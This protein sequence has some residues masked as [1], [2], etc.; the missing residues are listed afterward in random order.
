MSSFHPFASFLMQEPCHNTQEGKALIPSNKLNA[1][2]LL[3][4][5]SKKN[6]ISQTV[7][8]FLRSPPAPGAVPVRSTS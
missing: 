3:L 7:S 6:L 4:I 2:I 5:D 8:Q 1:L